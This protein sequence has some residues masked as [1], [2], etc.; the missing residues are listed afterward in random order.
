[1]SNFFTYGHLLI[2]EAAVLVI[3]LA[4]TLRKKLS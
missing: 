4:L 1:M 3:V 2:A